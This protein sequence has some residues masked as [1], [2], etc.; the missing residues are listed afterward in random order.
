MY[1]NISQIL[2]LYK[3]WWYYNKFDSTKSLG[4]CYWSVK[5]PQCSYMGLGLKLIMFYVQKHMTTLEICHNHLPVHN[6]PLG[7]PA[8]VNLIYR[9][10][11]MAHL[12]PWQHIKCIVYEAQVVNVCFLLLP[13]WFIASD[14]WMKW[15]GRC[16]PH[17]LMRCD[18]VTWQSI[19]ELHKLGLGSSLAFWVVKTIDITI[20]ST[21]LVVLSQKLINA[22]NAYGQLLLDK[23]IPITIILFFYHFTKLAKKYHAL[24][25]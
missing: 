1:S 6:K 18:L 14:L 11:I 3:T 4:V 17:S 8:S 25:R 24:S 9:S 16:L 21:W 22:L 13:K 15:S 10:S 20:T 7:V 19:K 23:D 5:I 2:L 12:Y